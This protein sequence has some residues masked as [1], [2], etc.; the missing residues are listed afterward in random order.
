MMEQ[1]QFKTTEA[2]IVQKLK[3]NELRPKFTGSCIKSVYHR[4]QSWLLFFS[5]SLSM[6]LRQTS[7]LECAFLQTII[8]YT[9]L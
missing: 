2:Q 7:I 4:G 8:S 6:I 5:Y 1:E 9:E 3:N